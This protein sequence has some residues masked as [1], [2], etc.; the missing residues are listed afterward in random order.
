M[1]VSF[2]KYSYQ[3]LAE[4]SSAIEKIKTLTSLIRVIFNSDNVV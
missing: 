4:I 2:V 3:F 1:H